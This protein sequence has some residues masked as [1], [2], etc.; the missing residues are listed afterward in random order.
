M[1]PSTPTSAQCPVLAV[2]E[3]HRCPKSSKPVLAPHI[4]QSVTAKNPGFSTI[5]HVGSLNSMTV[6][7]R[8]AGRAIHCQAESVH[9]GSTLPHIH[10]SERGAE[11]AGSEMRFSTYAGITHNSGDDWFDPVLT[12]DTPLYID[13]FLVFEDSNP[14]FSDSHELVIKFF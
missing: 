1:P 10:P 12:E 9:Q 7:K 3:F 13:P 4:Y 11:A 14:L 8:P 2:A 5:D 6:L